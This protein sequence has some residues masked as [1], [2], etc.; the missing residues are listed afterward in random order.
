MVEEYTFAGRK[1]RAVRRRTIQ[2]DVACMGLIR[3]ARLDT[4]VIE[5]GETPEAFSTR[6]LDRAL[7]D[8]NV[9]SLLGAVLIPAEIEDEDWTPLVMQ[10]TAAHLG[11]V[12]DEAEKRQLMTATVHMITGFFQSGLA[13]LRTSPR[14]SSQ[15][16][17]EAQPISEIGE[18][19]TMGTGS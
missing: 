7:C 11:R 14:S 16:T 5:E 8:G 3:G 10:A 19:T 6:L 12:A 9:F 17:A 1:F 2:N 13:S 15:S 4:V 18:V